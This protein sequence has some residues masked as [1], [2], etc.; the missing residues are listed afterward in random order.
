MDSSGKANS[1]GKTNINLR[2]ETC[3]ERNTW[4]L[5]LFILQ[6]QLPQDIEIVK[7]KEFL[8]I[9]SPMGNPI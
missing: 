8:G 2:Q 6:R 5:G 4:K 1:S 9:W 3:Q 7:F